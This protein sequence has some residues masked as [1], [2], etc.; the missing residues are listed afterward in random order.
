MYTVLPEFSVSDFII[1]HLILF[2]AHLEKL[3]HSSWFA[4]GHYN[5]VRMNMFQCLGGNVIGT[6]KGKQQNHY[7]T[8]A[9]YGCHWSA[10][11]SVVKSVLGQPNIMSMIPFKSLHIKW[12]C[13][14]G[15]FFTRRTLKLAHLEEDCQLATFA[16][17]KRLSRFFFF[18]QRDQ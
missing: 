14:A 12:Q 1:L 10:C 9:G 3:F 13:G 2:T 4:D 16:E 8:N 17:N 15:S 5:L 18:L 6:K 11:K 7:K